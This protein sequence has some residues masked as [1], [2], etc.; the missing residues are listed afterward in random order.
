MIN[1]S[2]PYPRSRVLNCGSLL[3]I[4]SQVFKCLLESKRPLVHLTPEPNWAS[5]GSLTMRTIVGSLDP[6]WLT[7]LK[8]Q[9]GGVQTLLKNHGHFFR[10]INGSVE[11]RRPEPEPTPRVPHKWK[12]KLCYFHFNHPNGCPLE[13][14]LCAF[15]H[16]AVVKQ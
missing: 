6:D 12:T 4:H 10:V 8:S 9:C 7:Y 5:G 15:S 14:H 16:D 3:F 13:E 11:L 2:M 1:Q